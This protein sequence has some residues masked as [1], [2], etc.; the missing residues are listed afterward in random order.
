MTFEKM[1]KVM[2]PLNISNHNLRRGIDILRES[3]A[4]VLTLQ[5]EKVV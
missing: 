4:S 1:E 5:E 2:P 3:I